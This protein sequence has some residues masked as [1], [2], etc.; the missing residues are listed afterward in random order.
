MRSGQ[1]Q[2]R[3]TVKRQKSEE[4]TSVDEL[5]SRTVSETHAQVGV[6]YAHMRTP[7]SRELI[8]AGKTQ[9]Q[10]SHLVT[11]RKPRFSIKSEDLLLFHKGNRR[12][13]VTDPPINIDERDRE[14]VLNCVELPEMTG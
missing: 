5:G 3:L 14:L 8:A 12:L 1:Y 7:T 11:I 2:H 6:V 4:S 9:G 13:S 10:L